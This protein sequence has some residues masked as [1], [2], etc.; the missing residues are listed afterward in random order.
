MAPYYSPPNLGVAIAIYF[1]HSV[2]IIKQMLGNVDNCFIT[3]TGTNHPII[4]DD[5]FTKLSEPL[6]HPTHNNVSNVNHWTAYESIW[7]LPGN[8]KKISSPNGEYHFT[9]PKTNMEPQW[10]GSM[11]SGSR[12]SRLTIASRGCQKT[13]GKCWEKTTSKLNQAKSTWW[14]QLMWKL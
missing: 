14:F 13:M 7:M 4:V 1:R 5:L 8:S 10:F 12:F 11:F 9:H 6:S 3:A 2:T